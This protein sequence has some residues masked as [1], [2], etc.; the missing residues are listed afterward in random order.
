MGR[1]SLPNFRQSRFM[2]SCFLTIITSHPNPFFISLVSC[3]SVLLTIELNHPAFH[4]L[5]LPSCL[6]V[7]VCALGVDPLERSGKNPAKICLPL[8]LVYALGFPNEEYCHAVAED[9]SGDG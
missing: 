7:I 9:D 5:R 3:L 6:P 1:T 4:Q 2:L 8:I